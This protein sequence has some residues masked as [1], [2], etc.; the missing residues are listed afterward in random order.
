MSWNKVLKRAGLNK[1]FFQ[2]AQQKQGV[3]EIINYCY[4]NYTNYIKS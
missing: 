3:T 1:L 2:K 4:V